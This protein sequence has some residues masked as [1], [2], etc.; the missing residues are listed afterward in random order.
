MD[1]AIF[2]VTHKSVEYKESPFKIAEHEMS[3]F[4][5][6][7]ECERESPALHNDKKFLYKYCT[8]R[9]LETFGD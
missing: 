8:V 2:K 3:E 5:D 6:F 9:E 4:Y 1:S 7:E